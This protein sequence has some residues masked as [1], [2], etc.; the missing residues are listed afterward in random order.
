MPFE[1]AHGSETEE[2]PFL[3]AWRCP[4]TGMLF[5]VRVR[6]TR[7]KPANETSGHAA[8]DGAMTVPGEPLPE[9][10]NMAHAQIVRSLRP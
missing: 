5:P 1:L 7:R 3:Q 2:S 8:S 6:S 10:R 4:D 9:M